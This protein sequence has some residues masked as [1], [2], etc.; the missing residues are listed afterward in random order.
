VTVTVVDGYRTRAEP[1]KVNSRA[2]NVSRRLRSRTPEK[3]YL[4]DTL[5]EQLAYNRKHM[6]F[7]CSLLV[8]ARKLIIGQ[9]RQFR[10]RFPDH[11]RHVLEIPRQP[12][13][14]GVI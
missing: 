6:A 7:E 13:E 10:G 14:E 8:S 9:G 5:L 12:S 11:K 3:L 4:Y 1:L 2:A